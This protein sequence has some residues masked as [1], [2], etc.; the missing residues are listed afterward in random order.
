MIGNL[1]KKDVEERLHGS[2]SAAALAIINKASIVRTHDVYET[3]ITK[4]IIESI[5]Y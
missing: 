3:K 1:L 2:L 4:N 5:I